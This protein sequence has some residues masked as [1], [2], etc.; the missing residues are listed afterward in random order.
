M[1][2]NGDLI[3]FT[4]IETQ[5]ENIQSLPGG[6]S[7]K[8][9]HAIL[10]PLAAQKSP[11]LSD[12]QNIKDAMAQEFEQ[13]L[14][15]AHDS[16]DPLDIYDRY[17]KWTMDAYPT[18]Q[19]TKESPLLPLL[20]R[21]TN[22]FL[23]SPL[24][25]SDPR[26]L[27]MWL[28][29]IRLFS[30]SPREMY[31]I[32][33][34]HGVGETLA[35]FYEEFAAWLET[36]GRWAQAEEVYSSGV[37]KEARPLERLIRKYGE[38][39]HRREAQAQ[40][41]DGSSSPALPK[42]RAALGVKADPL[43][44][45][46]TEHDPQAR[47]RV[48]KPTKSGKKLAIFS[49][50]DA[51]SA[52]GSSSSNQ[53]W[54]SIGSLN[55]RRK[56]NTYE[57]QPWAGQ[58]LDGGKRV[59]SGPKL[60]VF[61]KRTV[62]PDNG[63]HTQMVV[64]L[65]SM[66][67]DGDDTTGNEYCVEEL[68]ARH[69][70]WLNR[71][72]RKPRPHVSKSKPL[73]PKPATVS[74]PE[75]T[76]IEI[77]DPESIKPP[78]KMPIFADSKSMKPPPKKMSIFADAE[79]SKQSSKKLQVFEDVETSKALVKIPIFDDENAP[80]P[81]LDGAKRKARREE[82][83]NRTRKLE[84]LEV[85]A[86]PQT[87][88]TNLDSPSGPKKLRRTRSIEPTMT[89]NT[90]E[91]M[92]EVY[93]LF[94]QTL[95]DATKEQSED[96]ESQVDSDDD[97][98]I[99]EGES[100]GTGRISGAE[101]EYADDETEANFTESKT[102][103]ITAISIDNTQDSGW[104][105]FTEVKELPTH[106]K[107]DEDN[108]EDKE[109]TQNM[110]DELTTPTSPI[111]DA[112]NGGLHNGFPTM[113]EPDRSPRSFRNFHRGQNRLPFMT[114]IVEKTESSI[115]ALTQAAALADKDKDYFNTK[116]PSRQTGH[117][118]T[119]PELENWTSPLL[120][121]ATN[122][123]NEDDKENLPQPAMPK[124]IKP[125]VPLKSVPYARKEIPAIKALIGP[126]IRDLQC[127]P[128]NPGIHK[129]IL[130]HVQ[131]PIESY[132]G[133]F[134]HR[135]QSYKMGSKIRG[136]TKSAKAK[137]EKTMSLCAPPIVNLPGAARQYTVRRELGKGAFAPVYLVDSVRV[138]DEDENSPMCMGQGD[139]GV[140]RKDQEAIK[141]EDP[142]SAWEFYIIQ[143]AR[144][145]LGTTRP[146]ESIVHA[147]EMHLFDDECYLIEEFR[148]QGTLLDLVN[149]C[150]SEGNGGVMEEQ[151]VMF[152]T[153]ELF[154]TVEALH[155]KGIIHGD[156]KVDN[157]LV[158]LNTLP[159]DGVLSAQYSPTGMGSWA[160]KG[161]TLIDF[162]RG[163]DMK[164]FDPSVQFIADWKT[165]DA[166]C[167]EMR[168]MRP[169]TYQ[170]DYHGLAGV[171]HSLLYGKYLETIADKSQALGATKTYRVR[172]SLKR[173]WQTGI[174]GEVFGLLLNPGLHLEGEE[175]KKLPVLNG[176]KVVREK[177][178]SYLEENCEK[179]TGLKSLLKRIEGK[180]GERKK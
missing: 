23:T 147:Y 8:S 33:A 27:K 153:I 84:I 117:T 111:H 142:P 155:A 124:F 132:T 19:A 89:I 43:A 168:E 16:D 37:D 36:V 179:G 44:S 167:A 77:E 50:D 35:L 162:G 128:I 60:V 173:Y 108:E 110:T 177:M 154:R 95:T 103:D 144:R 171:V 76:L 49:D 122:N 98:Y 13:E 70:G 119:I 61:K 126:I 6:R 21:A 75:E 164:A 145:R 146:T 138:I 7:A 83:A 34:R 78:S 97:D 136:F 114:P 29:R 120:P 141:M 67:P 151:L 105:E 121:T 66:Y 176:M 20:E 48:A 88:Q 163:I 92:S 71:D 129:Q 74:P 11:A 62:N 45:V 47:D 123:E 140:L 14:A 161:V 160:E 93:D 5:K 72:W 170:V 28:L 152:F 3:D 57:A 166:D 127:N 68:R 9:L 137:G 46:P 165:S 99:S 174:W 69:R 150:R 134:D 101:S 87:I 32:L 100:T 172:E 149:I 135:G 85:K 156:I 30:D 112:E 25:K 55:E 143:Q 94:N 125:R 65:E 73:T 12:T 91:A 26:Y 17:I 86:E 106:N 158:R 102:L 90:K 178:E 63:R 58:K 180:V 54:D 118:S 82:K 169:W 18:A 40:Q 109:T 15:A 81:R 42:V 4:A 175:G 2:D 157:V 115:G 104:S 22:T 39:Q 41:D 59:A 56:E 1:A 51:S 159:N 148:N 38:F 80:Q 53:G 133:Y 130:S 107:D 139:F 113:G 10:A 79:T 31:A 131:P 24:Y 64:D 116:T 52:P 96:G